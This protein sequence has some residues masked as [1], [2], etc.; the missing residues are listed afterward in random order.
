LITN[1]VE[2]FGDVLFENSCCSFLKTLFTDRHY[3]ILNWSKK[4]CTCV[5]RKWSGNFYRYQ[6]SAGHLRLYL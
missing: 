1:I 2:Q 4:I 5:H 6:R 3:R